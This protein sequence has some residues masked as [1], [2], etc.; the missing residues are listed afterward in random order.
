MT[1][2]RRLQ[3][4][5]AGLAVFVL[6]LWLLGQVLLPFVAGAGVAYLLDP[7]ADRLERKG[8]SRLAATTIITVGFFVAVLLV[9]LLLVPVLQGQVAAF[10]ARLPGYV[11]TMAGRLAP[12]YDAAAEYLSPV[13][14]ERL[15]A[16]AGD[17]AG[18][19][20]A[21]AGKLLRGALSGGLLLVSLLSLLV[22]TPVVT[23]YLIRDWDRLVTKLDGLLPR[24][25]AEVIR[26]Q[27]REID[28]TLAGFVRGQ[29]SVCLILGAFYG[30]GL[31][32]V[33][34]DLG[35]VIGLGAGLL[36]FIPYV[37]GIAGFVTGVGLALAQTQDWVLPAL[38]AAVFLVG[39]A[40]EGNYLTPKLVGDRVGLH[41]VWVIF[42]LLAGGSL[43]GFVG[44]L[45]AVPVAAVVGV[46]VRFGLAR[47]LASPLYHGDGAAK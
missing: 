5:L 30:I 27:F 22:I 38:V 34:L 12:L 29:A 1:P 43:F 40:V 24:P 47:Y 10:L 25:H 4:W 39:Q 44:V 28:R 45:L 20:L 31:T 33:G 32:L 35:L 2:E 15:R 7:V 6:L 46:L 14:M 8:A 23:F 41:P 21:W 26:H 9:L 37:G 17:Y 18:T 3:F 42:A 11:E 36:S 19:A 16:A 13:E